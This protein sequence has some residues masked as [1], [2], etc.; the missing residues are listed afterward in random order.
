MPLKVVRNDII[1]MNTQAI[2]NTAGE[3]PEVGSGCETAIY[4]AAGYD[5]LHAC[6]EKIGDI[7]QGEVFI[8]PGFDLDAEYII[9][10]VSPLYIN[11]EYGEADLLR[12]CYK[13]S[14]ALAVEH[15]ITSIAFPLIATGSYGF[16]RAYGLRIALDEINSFLLDN[17]MD[18]YLVVFDTASTELAERLHPQMEAFI[19]HNEVCEIRK[20]EY[21]D[22]HF[23]SIS[24]SDIRYRTYADRAFALDERLLCT[25]K[26]E[27]AISINGIDTEK[28]DTDE[29]LVDPSEDVRLKEHVVKTADSFG[30]YV[31]Y[32]AERNGITLTELEN[33]A[34]ISK[35]VVFNIRKKGKNYKPDK[36]TAFQICVGLELSLEETKDLLMRAGYAISSSIMED[37]IWEYYIRNEHYDIIDISDALENYGLKPVITF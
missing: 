25:N 19:G 35:H 32:L 1:K 5:K 10:A 16:P 26:S 14:L 3:T 4:R 8:T 21:G 17:D 37:R 27:N 9:H 30:I 34:W 6:R 7:A 2:V 18:I 22:A 12:D 24:P 29:E 20:E 11:G 28:I 36:R 31:E 33:T 15:N 13:K 23:N